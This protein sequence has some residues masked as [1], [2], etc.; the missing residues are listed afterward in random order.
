MYKH[1]STKKYYENQDENYS[2]KND[3]KISTEH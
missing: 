3:K 2:T 1:W